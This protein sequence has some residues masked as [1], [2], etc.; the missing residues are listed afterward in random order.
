MM[1]RKLRTLIPGEESVAEI[2]KD[3]TGGKNGET[4]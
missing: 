1:M 2:N 3:E 4:D